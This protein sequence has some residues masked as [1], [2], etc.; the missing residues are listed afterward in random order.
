MP[1]DFRRKA[2]REWTIDDATAAVAAAVAAGED[3]PS[4]DPFNAADALGSGYGTTNGR[5]PIAWGPY[6]MNRAFIE[7]NDHWQNG[8]GW[9]G[10]NDTESLRKARPRFVAVNVLREGTQRVANALLKTEADVQFTPREP[11]PDAPK[12]ADQA[13][14]DKTAAQ[15]EAERAA[16]EVMARAVAAWW[17][18]VKLWAHARTA[19]MR[20]RYSTRGALR[21][22]IPPG[23]LA[24]TMREVTGENGSA[25]TVEATALPTN[26]S[27]EDALQRVALSAPAPDACT[28]Y[29]DPRTQRQCAIFLYEDDDGTAAGTSSKKRAELWFLDPADET[30]KAQTIARVVGEGIAAAEYHLS[31]GGRLP[32]AEMTADLLVTETE[33]MLQRSLNFAATTVPRTVET[34]GFAERV[35][36]NAESPGVFLPYPPADGSL[37]STR[38]GRDG[39]L[40]YLHP[41]AYVTGGSVVTELRG[42]ETTDTESRRQT[43]TTPEVVFKDPTDPAFA[44]RAVEYGRRMILESMHQGHVLA[45][46]EGGLSGYSR[47]QARADFEDDATNTKGPAEA[48]LR[49]I[50]ECLVAFAEEMGAKVDGVEGSFLAKYRCVVNIH[51][52]TGPVSPDEQRSINERVKDRQLSQESGMALAGVEDV[53]A[54]MERIASSPVARLERARLQGE[55]FNQWATATSTEFA[56]Q[57]AELTAEQ[58]AELERTTGFEEPEEEEEE[59]EDEER[60]RR[61]PPTGGSEDDDDDEEEE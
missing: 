43:L 18:R 14:I 1:A 9:I 22:W 27:L 51:V 29:T 32:I 13:A 59:E 10:P 35:V 26:L 19:V 60:D 28:V 50:L 11:T 4:P 39:K 34:A 41:L 12:G 24:R 40:Y 61:R 46:G 58:L 45:N 44:I 33:R 37:V 7:L 3:T 6:A 5:G 17:D 38:E 30:E 15:Q 47:E 2:F 16:G 42:I 20:S 54:E 21:L 53:P 55:V 23:R 49:D 52:N 31:L 56:A 57:M 48:M 25:R 36:I 8:R